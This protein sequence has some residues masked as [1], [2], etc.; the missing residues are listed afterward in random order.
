MQIRSINCYILKVSR[1]TNI[2]YIGRC[3][4]LTY[5]ERFVSTVCC[6]FSY[7]SWS[8]NCIS[9][10]SKLNNVFLTCTGTEA[11][12]IFESFI[13]ALYGKVISNSPILFL[14]FYIW[15]VNCSSGFFRAILSVS[16]L[17]ELSLWIIEHISEISSNVRNNLYLRPCN[18]AIYGKFYLYCLFTI[19]TMFVLFSGLQIVKIQS[20]NYALYFG[21]VKIH[22]C[23]YWSVFMESL[24]PAFQYFF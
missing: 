21:S 20:I 23:L 6:F 7:I 16:K 19:S 24:I 3:L 5:I 15:S 8:V 13:F 17:Y 22:K 10:L 11:R 12:F 1:N 9:G 2:V 4:V 14:L 18:I